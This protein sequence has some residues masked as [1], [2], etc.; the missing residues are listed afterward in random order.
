MGFWSSDPPPEVPVMDAATGAISDVYILARYQPE[1]LVA[2]LAL[3]VLVCFVLG[4]SPPFKGLAFKLRVYCAG[5]IHFW[6]SREAKVGNTDRTAVTRPSSL[7]GVSD[8]VTKE[9]IFIRHG[10]SEWNEVFNR[11]KVMLV[12]RLVVGIVREFFHMP[13][14]HQSLF[15]DSPLGATGYKQCD[16]LAQ[17]LNKTPSLSVVAEQ[18]G[19]TPQ[20]RS[21]IFTSNLRR[22]V[23]TTLIGLQPRLQK[24]REQ[25]FVYSCLQEAAPNVDTMALTPAK[26]KPQINHPLADL[27][28]EKYNF[29]SKRWHERAI[30]R[31][32]IFL[33]FSFAREEN[34]V[35]AVGHSLYF[36]KF[37]N[38]YLDDKSVLPEQAE[39]AKKKK[40]PN[41]GVVKFKVQRGKKT[42][43]NSYRIVPDSIQLLHGQWS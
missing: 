2:K 4:S 9:F 19:S 8:V 20:S 28:D 5:V 1:L 36:R 40:V 22:C 3:V 26:E 35:I 25:V 12:P 38:E 41:C 7:I 23:Q 21:V 24:T 29:G 33:K 16:A 32:N 27:L 10:E 15:L 34:R 14:K 42:L 18:G 43:V 37:F 39:M 17:V 31:M 6:A 11:S 13:F 30:K